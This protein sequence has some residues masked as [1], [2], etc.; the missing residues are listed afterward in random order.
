MPWFALDYAKLNVVVA[1]TGCLNAED[2][3]HITDSGRRCWIFIQ[4]DK[5]IEGHGNKG[6]FERLP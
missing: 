6:V 2:A 5:L 1:D 3:K 4:G